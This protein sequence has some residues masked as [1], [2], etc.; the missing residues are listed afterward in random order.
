MDDIS[1]FA[2]KAIIPTD[3]DLIDILGSTYDLWQQIN[4]LVFS[5]YP[6]G[7]AEWNFPGKKYGW[8][9]RIKDKRRAIIYLLP[10]DK[11]F[12]VALIFGEKATQEIMGSEV[13]EA[14]KNELINSKKYAEGRSISIDISDET[15][16][17]DESVISDIEQL[18]IIKLKY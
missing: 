16:I 5:K 14:I 17:N 13:S 2:D 1:I 12:K 11:Y 15:V 10:R 18:V 6:N 4:N 3:S 7:K 9:Y 8:S